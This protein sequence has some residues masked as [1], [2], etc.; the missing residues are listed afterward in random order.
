MH[1][2]T[3]KSI[4]WA[5][6]IGYTNNIINLSDD[7]LFEWCELFL[8]SVQKEANRNQQKI[9]SIAG[10]AIASAVY[11]FLGCFQLISRSS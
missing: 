7:S 1:T 4:I 6:G 10:I 8:D 2:I 3:M 5:F 11:L 9:H